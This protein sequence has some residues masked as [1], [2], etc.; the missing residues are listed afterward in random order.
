MNSITENYLIDKVK[1]LEER[2]IEL[3]KHTHPPIDLAPFVQQEI[4]RK[5]A[6][7]QPMSLGTIGGDGV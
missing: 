6:H 4:D 7:Y 1:E 3:E 2:V 5:L